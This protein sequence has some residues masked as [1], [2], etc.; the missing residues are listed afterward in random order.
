MLL[1]LCSYS[2]SEKAVLDLEEIIE[3][4]LSEDEDLNE[5]SFNELYESLLYY[6]EHPQD[7]N[8]IDAEFLSSTRILDP[9]QAEQ[10]LNYRRTY[11]DFIALEE[12]QAIEGFNANIIEN[13][14]PFVKLGGTDD[15]QVSLPRMFAEGKS[16][17]YT[18]WQRVLE[19]Q[20][21]YDADQTSPY[22]G[23][24]DKYTLR[25]RYEYENRMKLGFLAEKDAGELFFQ[26]RD[27]DGQ[28][29]FNS[30][31]YYSAFFHLKNYKSWLKDFIIGDY[32]VSLGQGIIMHNNFGSGKGSY[33]TQIKKDGRPVR[34]YGS[35]AE[36]NYFRGTTFTLAPTKRLEITPFISFSKR[37]AN[38][39][40]IQD[41]ENTQVFFSSI[42]ESGDH[43]TESEIRKKNKL[44]Q[45][46]T[47]VNVK[48]SFEDFIISGYS[49][50]FSFGEKLKRSDQ[51]YNTFRFNGDK[52]LYNGLDYTWRYKNF[53]FFGEVVHADTGSIAYLNGILAALGPK[54]SLAILYRDYPREF[55][56]LRS[57]AFG[58]GSAANNESGIYLGLDVRPNYN[59]NFSS[60]I[61]VW[62]F[63]WL[64]FGVDKPST[65]YELL[66]KVTYRKKRKYS[67]YLQYVIEKKE[68]NY[69]L[70][71]SAVSS[72]K[73]RFRQRA[74]IHS[75]VDIAKGIQ[76]RNRIEFSFYKHADYSSNGFMMYQDIIYKPMGSSF[77]FTGRVALFDTDDFNSAI[78]VYENDILYEFY[79]PAYADRGFRTY[80]NVRYNLTFDTMLEFRIARTVLENRE[81]IGSGKNRID[82]NSRTDIKMQAKFKF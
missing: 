8:K 31:D 76:L 64:R 15:F 1:P 75:T 61:D 9:L 78:Y 60:Y 5:S 55:P 24:K 25:Y 82:G 36:N 33:V 65:G 40:T 21:G 66:G 2:Q 74:R 16:T 70:S 62:K 50:Y 23:S 4:I 34:S 26:S 11:G 48:Y 79:I 18:K 12:L 3:S 54:A 14:L 57:N 41:F 13:L 39:D 35:V 77:S 68:R 67:A 51:L 10:F 71:Q 56:S 43:R 44:S 17:L 37:D 47:G 42:L 29:Q 72:V 69:T 28:K 45:F 20:Q 80:L 7:L 46:V 22:L 53:N 58:E 63:P 30:F 32:T 27:I 49:S 38:I 52:L 73:N 59:W 19:D 81:T 6:Y